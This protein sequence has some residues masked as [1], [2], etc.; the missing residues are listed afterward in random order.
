MSEVDRCYF[1][2][3]TDNEVKEY[4][5]N[6]L[7]IKNEEQR[8]I[9]N[10][11]STKLEENLQTKIDELKHIHSKISELP[12]H[13][14]NM[15]I[16]TIRAEL[17]NLKT[18]FP[19]LEE[20][21]RYSVPND[22]TMKEILEDYIQKFT[23]ERDEKQVLSR[24]Q[25]NVQ[26]EKRRLLNEYFNEDFKSKIY[27]LQVPI[28]AKMNIRKTGAPKVITDM[29][30]KYNISFEETYNLLKR[31]A[32]LVD[33]IVTNRNRYRDDKEIKDAIL[34]SLQDDDGLKI[35]IDEDI[36]TFLTRN[37]KSLTGSYEDVRKE[38]YMLE[39]IEVPI[40][41]VCQSIVER[42]PRDGME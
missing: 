22:K 19:V 42:I 10:N 35:D 8:E 30:N 14:R 3:R 18:D 9:Q 41:Y 28:K 13:I 38:F 36:A 15:K 31:A 7:T 16:S 24:S 21:L 26:E 20:A 40:C 25:N 39:K 12:S 17:N 2:G 1:C 34:R 5:Q 27:K 6:V 33:P 37:Y 11:T 23:A 4:F 29:M 32:V